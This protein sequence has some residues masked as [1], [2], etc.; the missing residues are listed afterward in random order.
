VTRRDS[1]RLAALAHDPQRAVT[2]IDIHVVDVG[3][4]GF[5]D[6]QPVHRQQ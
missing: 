4:E 3:A 2:A 5:A 1:D 6:P